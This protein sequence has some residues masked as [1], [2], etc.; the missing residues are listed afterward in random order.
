MLADVPVTTIL[1]VIDAERARGF[2]RDALGLEHLGANDEGQELFRIGPGGVL[3][4][5]PKPEGQPA[6]HTVMSFEVTDITSRIRDLS[7]RGVVFADYDLPSL[8]TVDHVCV[9]GSEKAAWFTDTEGNILC[10]H[11]VLKPGRLR[12]AAGSDEA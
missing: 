3:A 5:M 7:G 12:P 11:E 2:Y 10:L 6:A 4:L 1:P 9:L 8:R